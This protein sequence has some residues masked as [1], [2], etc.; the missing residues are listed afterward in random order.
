MPTAPTMLQ[1]DERKV[2]DTEGRHRKIR[3]AAPLVRVRCGLMAVSSVACRFPGE[4]RSL[5]A[6]NTMRKATDEA[7]PAVFRANHERRLRLGAASRFAPRSRRPAESF[8][9]RAGSRSPSSATSDLA[10]LGCVIVG[11][12]S[13]S[14]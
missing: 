4:M 1:T 9:V 5:G 11:P 8:Q 7:V 10:V 6:L 3:P 2:R 14:R 12:A 13:R